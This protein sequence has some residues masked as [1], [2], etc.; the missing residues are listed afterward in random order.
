V[1]QLGRL[2]FIEKLLRA[3]DERREQIEGLIL[4]GQFG[5]VDYKAACRARLTWQAAREVIV[6]ALSE[7]EKAE[8]SDRE[9]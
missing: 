4:T 5:E 8:I 3:F 7:D 1:A 9:G 6:D 2:G